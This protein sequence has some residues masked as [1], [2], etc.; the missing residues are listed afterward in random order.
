MGIPTKVAVGVAALSAGTLP[1]VVGMPGA[2]A[3][4]TRTAHHQL[5]YEFSDGEGISHVCHIEGNSTLFR[6]TGDPTFDSFSDVF[7]SGG[8]SEC[9]ATVSVSARYTNADGRAR[10][11]SA[12]GSRLV[13]LR[14]D[15]VASGYVATHRVTF[16]N[17]INFCTTPFDTTPK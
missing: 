15:D 3:D 8:G 13:E 7:V 12:T 9:D 11:S 16:V 1:F 2:A 14:N 17:C 6:P 10:V 4:E 5:D